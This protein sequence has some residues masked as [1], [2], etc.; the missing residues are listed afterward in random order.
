LFYDTRATLREPTWL[1][2]GVHSSILV[3]DISPLVR[4]SREE[5]Q[6]RFP[7][8][9]TFPPSTCAE[10][11]KLASVWS[12]SQ[13]DNSHNP[14]ELTEPLDWARLLPEGENE[15]KVREVGLSSA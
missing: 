5:I 4:S 9:E 14:E 13:L 10:K 11:F 2:G 1:T 6:D 7:F 3:L 15:N 8:D 12:A